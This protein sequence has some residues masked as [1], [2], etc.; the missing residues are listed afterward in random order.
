MLLAYGT[1]PLIIALVSVTVLSYVVTTNEA[2][3]LTVGLAIGAVWTVM[4]I[5]LGL[6]TVHNYSVKETIASIVLTFVLMGVVVVVVMVV[7]IMW[8]QVWSFLST[9]GE[10]LKQYVFNR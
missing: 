3:F 7:T 2:F 4:L 5:F 9:V 1:M 6:Q 10:E 8:D